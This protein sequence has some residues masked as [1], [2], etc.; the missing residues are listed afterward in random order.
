METMLRILLSLSAG[1]T[2]LAA[3]LM[4]LRRVLKTRMPAAFAYYAWLL[5][6]LRFVLPLPGLLPAAEAPVPARPAPMPVVAAAPVEQ[7]GAPDT[8]RTYRTESAQGSTAASAAAPI[9]AAGSA[10]E[11]EKPA[12]DFA[13]LLSAAKK[14]LG[15]WD[16]WGTVYL[17]GAGISLLRYGVG[18]L[19]FRRALGRTF[20]RARESDRLVL[21][22]LNSTPWPAL[23]RSRAVRTPMLLGLLRPVIVLPDRDYDDEMLRGILRHELT[24]YRRGD[25]AYKWFAVLVSSLHWFNPFFSLFRREIDRA[26]ELSCDERLLRRMGRGETAWDL[27]KRHN[28]TVADILSANHLEDESALAGERLILIPK[29]RI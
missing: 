2:L 24:H 10:A 8:P 1:G 26:C 19:R 27:A 20:R 29:K 12:L 3:L 28:T 9:P 25:L 11:E 22:A 13:A 23:C 18:F 7:S 14:L 4:L 16:F 15:S 6:L 21:E 17:A 5:V